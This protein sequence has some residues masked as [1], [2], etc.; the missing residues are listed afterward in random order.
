MRPN[1]SRLLEAVLSSVSGIFVRRQLH[2]AGRACLRASICSSPCSAQRL[3]ALYLEPEIGRWRLLETVVL[4]TGGQ[5][6]SFLGR[7]RHECHTTPGPDS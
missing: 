2:P 3:W 7:K 1:A 4:L 6:V 5:N